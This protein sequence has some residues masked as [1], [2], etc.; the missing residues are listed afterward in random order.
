[1]CGCVCGRTNGCVGCVGGTSGCV[2]C[3]G[4][5][6]GVWVGGVGGEGWSPYVAV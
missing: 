4:V 6:V 1:M 3:V 2:G 5:G